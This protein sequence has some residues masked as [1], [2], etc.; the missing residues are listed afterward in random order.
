MDTNQQSIQAIAPGF[1]DVDVGRRFPRFDLAVLAETSS[2]AT[3]ADLEGEPLWRE[4]V[5]MIQAASRRS[6]RL[7]ADEG[8]A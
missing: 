5:G 4:L 8:S 6:Y 7:V 3:A 1:A 2:P